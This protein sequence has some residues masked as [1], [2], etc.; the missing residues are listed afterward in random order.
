MSDWVLAPDVLARARFAVSTSAETLAA[1]GL[2]RRGSPPPWLAGWYAR[3]AAAYQMTMATRP[4]WAAIVAE[5]F[6]PRWVADCLTAAPER[7]GDLVEELAGVR[8]LSDEQVRAD[9]R[10]THGRDRLPE[11]LETTTGLGDAVADLMQWTWDTTL[12][13]EWPRRRHVLEADVVSRTAALASGGWSAALEG[14]GRAYLGEG[15]VRISGH[16]LPPKH[17]GSGATLSFHPVSS[18]TSSVLWHL[19]AQRYAIVYQASG[20]GIV[21]EAVAPQALHRLLGSNRARILGL[22]AEPASTT[23]LAALIGLP[24]GSVGNH[25]TVLREAGLVGRRRSGRSVLYR[26]TQAGDALVASAAGGPP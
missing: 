3:H 16:Q 12:A 24:V 25:L 11:V 8:A 22:L 9:L 10:Q 18:P 6:G 14:M 26:R 23:Q 20:M 4:L 7:V 19:P 15:R 21:A 17:L 1:L 5:G 13:E 2:L